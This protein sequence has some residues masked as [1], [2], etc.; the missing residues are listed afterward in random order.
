MGM[1]SRRRHDRQGGPQPSG[2]STGPYAAGV[3]PFGMPL[4]VPESLDERTAR[5][6]VRLLVSPGAVGSEL[7]QNRLPS[8]SVRVDSAADVSPR[9]PSPSSRS[10]RD[11]LMILIT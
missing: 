8:Q 7:D 9:R 1:S 3:P 6:A 10:T 2:R 4:P 5:V 11:E